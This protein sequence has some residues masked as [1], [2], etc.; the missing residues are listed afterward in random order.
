[1]SDSLQRHL[2]AARAALIA[3]KAP[4]ALESIDRFMNAARKTPPTREQGSKLETQ[5]SELRM[6]ADAGLEGAKS[7]AGQLRAIVETARSLQTYDD[8][9][10]RN[11]KT[12]VA[13]LPRRY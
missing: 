10:Q 7:A 13:P 12:V 4:A 9:G 2:A 6:L 1:M 11:V 8:A 5:I 3:G